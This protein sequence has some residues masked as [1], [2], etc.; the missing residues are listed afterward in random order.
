MTKIDFALFV[1]SHIKQFWPNSKT[2]EFVWK[3]G[4]IG[5]LFSDFAVCQIEPTDVNSDW[6][7]VSVG[8]SEIHTLDNEHIEFFILSANQDATLIDTIAMIANLHADSKQS[9]HLGK[10]IN[11]GR[12]W[13]GDSKCD[14]FLVSLPYTMSKNFEWFSR[15]EIKIR[16]L[17]LLP[18]TSSEAQYA[19]MHRAEA[20]EERFE[21]KGIEYLDPNRISAV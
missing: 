2:R 9:L 11:I 13:L 15:N 10:I 1:R 3:S 20:L 7:Y 16:F 17:W 8:A 14:H 4:P 19:R 5:R 21:E 6:V 18:I 12:P